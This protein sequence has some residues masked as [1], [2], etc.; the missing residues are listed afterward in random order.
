MKNV[1]KP[2]TIAITSHMTKYEDLSNLCCITSLATASWEGGPLAPASSMAAISSAVSGASW[3]KWEW[4]CISWFD[5]YE[6]LRRRDTLEGV[7]CSGSSFGDEIDMRYE[8][9]MESKWTYVTIA[10]PLLLTQEKITWFG[11]A[12]KRL[13]A[14]LTTASTG[15]PGLRVIELSTQIL[16]WFGATN[17]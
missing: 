8:S 10:T 13:A 14:A 3:S 15:P 16:A 7:P 12:P 6:D 1:A 2:N 11:V 4:R 17:S 9:Y 5:T